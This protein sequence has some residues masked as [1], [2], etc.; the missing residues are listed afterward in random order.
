MPEVAQDDEREHPDTFSEEPI[1]LEALDKARWLTD[2]RRRD[3]GWAEMCM[4][5][6]MHSGKIRWF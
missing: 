3:L 2:G 5:S 6:E 4:F 1:V